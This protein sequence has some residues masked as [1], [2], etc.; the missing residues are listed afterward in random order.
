MASKSEANLFAEKMLAAAGFKSVE[1]RQLPPDFI[2]SFCV[3]R[4]GV[5]EE[6]ASQANE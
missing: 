1:V 6:M 4:K 5:P 2:N 3:A